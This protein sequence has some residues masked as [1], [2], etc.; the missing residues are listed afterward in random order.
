MINKQ[1][2][3]SN[4]VHFLKM[5]L[6]GEPYIQNIL[7]QGE[8]SNFTRHK[9]GHIYFTLKDVKSRINC[10]MF[11]SHAIGLSFLPKEGDKV[12][13]RCTTSIFEATGQLQL[14]VK[15]IQ[16]DGLGDLYLRLNQLKE[17]LSRLG[18]FD[19]THKKKIPMYPSKVAMISGKDSAAYA[20][21]VKTFQSR[22][23]LAEI[24]FLPTLVQG[25]GAANQLVQAIKQLDDGNIDC[26]ILARG[27]GS[28]EDLWAFNDAKLA[29]CIYHAKTPIICG[30]GHESDFTIAE[31]VADLRAS[32]PTA[33]V[34]HACADKTGCMEAL[35]EKN[36]LLKDGLARI[37]S[38]KKQQLNELQHTN[39]FTN[40]DY[41]LMEP[42]LRVDYLRQRLINSQ[43]LLNH[44]RHQIQSKMDSIQQIT[45]NLFNKNAHHLGINIEKLEA[46]S[47]LKILSRGYQLMSVDGKLVKS[48]KQLKTQ[49]V[50]D[51]KL[52]DGNAKAMI[53]EVKDE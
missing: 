13:V 34:M 6:D 48:I 19:E 44:K 51:I 50:V 15:S 7:V 40:K 25:E 20:D 47:P 43:S 4:L 42:T 23:P 12:V 2:S 3:V 33:C 49:D 36:R 16:L 14:Y 27:G 52:H 21:M 53:M 46:Y 30:V 28:I 5:K 8:I 39:V 41:L 24:F 38:A 1:I 26:I 10:V 18:Y 32:T 35:Q 22:W 45:L 17:S 9:S 37:L 29:E 31:M 11:Q